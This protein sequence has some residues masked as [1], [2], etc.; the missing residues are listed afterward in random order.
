MYVIRIDFFVRQDGIIITIKAPGS[1]QTLWILRDRESEKKLDIYCKTLYPITLSPTNK[2]QMIREMSYSYDR[3]WSEYGVDFKSLPQNA[4]QYFLGDILKR[5]ILY[6]PKEIEESTAKDDI[7]IQLKP[8]VEAC[9]YRTLIG[10]TY[11]YPLT[12]SLLGYDPELIGVKAVVYDP[13]KVKEA[14]IYFLVNSEHWEFTE[15]EKNNSP[16][17]KDYQKDM[18]ADYSWLPHKL[19][20]KGYKKLVELMKVEYNDKTEPVLTY[21]GKNGPAAIEQLEC[22]MIN[23]KRAKK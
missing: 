10:E 17:R 19:R 16:K 12:I 15:E 2:V 11:K 21:V 3:L 14:G 22:L 4:Q 1:K 6:V 20:K 7:Q 23:N 8:L 9:Y 5:S 18:L 13:I